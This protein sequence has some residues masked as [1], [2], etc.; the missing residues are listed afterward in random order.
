MTLTNFFGRTRECRRFSGST[1]LADGTITRGDIETFTIQASVQFIDSRDNQS[2]MVYDIGGR[3]WKAMYNCY[4]STILRGVT[5][6]SL[7]EQIW[8]D[9]KWFD[10]V[11]SNVTDNGILGHCRFFAVILDEQ[12]GEP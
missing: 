6:S 4:S 5:E 2:V 7:G 11:V 12:P 8:I 3:R 1:V 10:V 9:G